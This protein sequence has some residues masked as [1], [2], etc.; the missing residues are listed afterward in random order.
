MGRKCGISNVL[1]H[2]NAPRWTDGIHSSLS[3]NSSLLASL[4]LYSAAVAHTL[5]AVA[6]L[7][8]QLRPSGRARVTEY[9][10]AC[11]AVMLTVEP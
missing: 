7:W 1:V 5:H 3:L 9:A 8:W 10:T 11:A 2:T 6:M 4:E